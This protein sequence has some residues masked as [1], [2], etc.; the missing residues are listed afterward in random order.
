M[1]A[2]SSVVSVLSFIPFRVIKGRD[3]V[4]FA[5]FD[6]KLALLRAE[7]IFQDKGG[8]LFV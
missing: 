2:E 7:E 3:A 5:F 6:V 4:T 8:V 1:K